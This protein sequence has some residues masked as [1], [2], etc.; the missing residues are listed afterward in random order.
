MKKGQDKPI[1]YFTKEYLDRC[2][3]MDPEQIIEFLENYR[4][5]MGEV[6]EKCLLISLRVE[7]SLLEAFKRQ[8]S[9]YGIAYQKQIKQLM[10]AWLLHPQSFQ[11]L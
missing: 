2:K 7:P 9:L 4:T 11:N 1:Q 8:A 10:K 3:G 6:S 5:L